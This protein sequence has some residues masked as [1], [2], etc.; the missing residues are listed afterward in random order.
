MGELARKDGIDLVYDNFDR[1][2]ELYPKAVGL[3]QELIEQE[4]ISYKGYRDNYSHASF[5]K[6]NRPK[7][8]FESHE[9]GLEV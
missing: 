9:K 4:K 8:L 5:F 7:R 2:E 6:S 1:I 3:L